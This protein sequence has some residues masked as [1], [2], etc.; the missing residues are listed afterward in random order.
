MWHCLLILELLIFRIVDLIFSLSTVYF[1]FYC[2][3][4]SFDLSIVY[5]LLLSTLLN[6]DFFL[7][8]LF[9]QLSFMFFN[10][11]QRGSVCSSSF[12]SSS[13]KNFSNFANVSLSQ[14]LFP[15]ISKGCTRL[16]GKE[17]VMYS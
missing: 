17:S 12:F 13:N 2:L 15:F 8:C 3:L 14:V 16:I 11:A 9:F 4:I 1:L 10:P 6:F 7:F 5:L